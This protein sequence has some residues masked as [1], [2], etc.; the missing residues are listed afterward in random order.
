MIDVNEIARLQEELR[1][2]K[3]DAITKKRATKQH[4]PIMQHYS[5]GAST[6]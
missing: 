2:Q 6:T 3:E 4:I 5:E 1:Q